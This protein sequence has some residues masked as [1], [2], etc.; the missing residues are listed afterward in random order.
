MQVSQNE[1]A[2]GI[3]ISLE[4]AKYGSYEPE[5]STAIRI[6]TTHDA[7]QEANFPSLV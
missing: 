5:K 4:A 2:G 1:S 6:E 7:P 3:I